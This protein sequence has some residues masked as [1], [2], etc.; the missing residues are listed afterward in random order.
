M[1]DSMCI[2]YNLTTDSHRTATGTGIAE[3]IITMAASESNYD[4]LE[5]AQTETETDTSF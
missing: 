3:W 2:R 1:I 5:I 4:E